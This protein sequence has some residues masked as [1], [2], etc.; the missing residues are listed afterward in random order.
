MEAA[1]AA[2]RA[3]K[4]SKLWSEKS[5]TGFETRPRPDRRSTLRSSSISEMNS[6][7]SRTSF[8]PYFPVV[9]IKSNEKAIPG[10]QQQ[11]RAA[12]VGQDQSRPVRSPCLK[13]LLTS[14]LAKKTKAVAGKTL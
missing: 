10:L 7:A 3:E 6:L 9:S 11:T 1:T 8:T 12:K 5:E 2:I 13:I 14:T 4:R